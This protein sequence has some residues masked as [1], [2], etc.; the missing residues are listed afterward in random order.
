MPIFTSGMASTYLTAGCWSP[1]RPGVIY[2][3][4]DDGSIEVRTHQLPPAR[5]SSLN[6]SYVSA[7][8]AQKVVTGLSC[9]VWPEAHEANDAPFGHPLKELWPRTA[10][11]MR[12]RSSI[13]S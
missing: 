10:A 1:T 7:A 5:P 11:A 8:A 2:T 13:R 9:V 3:A 6:L 4:R 12:A